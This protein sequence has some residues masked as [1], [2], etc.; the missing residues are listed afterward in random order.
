MPRP[1]DTRPLHQQVAADL[2]AK[3]MA[4]DLA[5]GDQLP[6]TTQLVDRYGAANPTIQKV[7]TALRE[8]GYLHSRPGAGVYVRDRRPFVV[9]IAAYFE[10]MPNGY[11][12][13]LLDVAETRPPADAAQALGLGEDGTAILRHRLLLHDGEPVEI[14]WSYYPL[15]LAAG[16]PLARR[17]RIRGG[18]PRVLAD[19]GWPQQRLTD[20]ISARQ[21][22]TAELETLDLP[23]DVPVIRQLRTIYSGERPVEASVLVKGAHLYEL[24]YWQEIPDES[25][26]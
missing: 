5:P 12:Y 2:R 4:G 17:L 19:Q 26:S 7:T 3:I 1:R 14:S 21:P 8:E 25:A 9:D 11:A 13:Q 10:P 20:R 23:S 22:T 15:E 16:T 24:Q 18:A 6:S